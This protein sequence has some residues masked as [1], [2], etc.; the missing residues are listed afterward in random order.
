MTLSERSI[1]DKNLIGWRRR[2]RGSLTVRLLEAR[3]HSSKLTGH[4]SILAG[5]LV[6]AAQSE[7]LGGSLDIRA[8]EVEALR[9]EEIVGQREGAPL[10]PLI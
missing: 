2:Q 5:G 7:D 9:A 1:P 10:A 6:A 4:A 3:S 8:A